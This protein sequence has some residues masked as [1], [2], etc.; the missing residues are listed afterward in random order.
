MPLD[1]SS[2]PNAT[3]ASQKF[4]HPQTNHFHQ[5]RQGPAKPESCSAGKA[6]GWQHAEQES[7]ACPGTRDGWHHPLL[8]EQT[9]QRKGLSHFT[10]Q[11]LDHRENSIHFFPCPAKDRHCQTKG[12]LSGGQQDMGLEPLLC[13]GMLK[14]GPCSAWGRSDFRGPNSSQCLQGY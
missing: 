8:N 2:S 5:G 3:Q 7:A 11:S 12:S 13:K 4:R 9:D 1:N 14:S 10:K 6:L